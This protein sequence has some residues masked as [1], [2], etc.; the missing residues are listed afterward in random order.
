ML[1]NSFGL[2]FFLKTPKGRASLRYIYLRISVDG[3]SKETSTKRKWEMS[4]WDQKT[5]RAIGTKEDARTLNHFLNSLV[6]GIHQFKTELLNKGK[7]ITAQRIMDFIQGKDL[8]RAKV[9]EEFQLHNDEMLALVAK[10]EYAL[11]THV[12]FE[13][14]L[15]HVKAFIRKKYRSDDLEFRELN[16]EFVKDFEFYLKTEKDCSN[17]TALKYIS[18]FKKIVLRAVAKEIIPSDPFKLF[19][20]KKTRTNKKPL[21]REELSLIEQK[22]F[23]SERLEVVRDV[24]VF[25]CYTGLAY[26]DVFQLKKTEIKKG[27]DGGLWI[28]TEREKTGSEVNVPLLPQALKIIEKYKE[29]PLCKERGSVLPVRTNQKMNEYLK[30]IATLCG[31]TSLLNTHKA[32]RTFASTVTLNNGVPIHVVKEMLGH[33]SVKQTEEYALTEQMA[34]SSEMNRLKERL[35]PEKQLS[36]ESTLERIEKELELLK[37]HSGSNP[38]LV[39]LENEILQLKKQIS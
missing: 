8:S 1:E 18:N 7:T 10:G 27:I 34:I 37:K 12:R 39:Y 6:S 24:F 31:V 21:S 38:K 11:G 9:V 13:T 26:I 4:R 14:T 17:N 36:E 35:T 5:E 15:A 28:M 29:H 19:K 20:G 16:F 2:T 32:R 23:N 33:E 25:Q 3:I 30:E 22:T